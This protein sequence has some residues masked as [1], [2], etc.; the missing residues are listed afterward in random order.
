M[1]RSSTASIT[2]KKKKVKTLS[3]WFED[4]QGNH[5]TE[6]ESGGTFYIVGEYLENG[7]PLS[8]E[9]IHIYLT[10]SAGNP[11]DF[12]AT[13]RTD[14]NGR[15]SCPTQAPSVSSDTDLYFRAYDDE[16]KPAI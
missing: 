13:V 1:T 8:N 16:Q 2:V 11:T 6:V 5:N 12:I 9:K 7:T 3:M 10:D 4:A 14:A 15:Y